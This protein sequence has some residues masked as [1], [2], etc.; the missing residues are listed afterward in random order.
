VDELDRVVDMLREMSQTPP[1]RSAGR[2]R[3]NPDRLPG[4][5]RDRQGV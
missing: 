2:G 1:G 4:R 3:C 5:P